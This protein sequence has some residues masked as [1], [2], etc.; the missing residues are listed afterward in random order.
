MERSFSQ[1]IHGSHFEKSIK[2]GGTMSI[3][4]L[5]AIAKVTAFLIHLLAP[6]Y[7]TAKVTIYRA[8][9]IPGGVGLAQRSHFIP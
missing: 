9:P 2:Y 3:R 7:V 1:Q 6:S 5:I 4:H 8:S